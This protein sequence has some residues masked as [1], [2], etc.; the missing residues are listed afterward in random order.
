MLDLAWDGLISEPLDAPPGPNESEDCLFLDVWV[1]NET[2]HRGG[3]PVI[4]WIHGGGYIRRDKT[5]GG[6]PVG[7]L[8]RSAELEGAVFVAIGYRVCVL[9]PDR[10]RARAHQITT[11]SL[12]LL[13]G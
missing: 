2:F 4:V 1:S 12:E 10:A 13:G 5:E 11:P 8:E 3:A 6:S 7:L 9:P